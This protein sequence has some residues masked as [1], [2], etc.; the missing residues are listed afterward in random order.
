MSR[1]D[2]GSDRS[3]VSGHGIP[4]L[5]GT[6]GIVSTFFR[7]FVYHPVAGSLPAIS[8]LIGGTV[9]H[10]SPTDDQCSCIV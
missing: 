10:P 7:K 2:Q 1:R 6:S 9:L 5:P 8:L 3:S 4:T